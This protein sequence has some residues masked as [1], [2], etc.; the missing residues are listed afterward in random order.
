MEMSIIEF[1]ISSLFQRISTIMMAN[2]KLL[3]IVNRMGFFKVWLHQMAFIFCIQHSKINQVFSIPIKPEFSA[4]RIDLQA[5]SLA[6]PH[7][8]IQG[9]G[10][11]SC[12]TPQQPTIYIIRPYA[13]LY[14]FQ[15]RGIGGY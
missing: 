6:R 4:N 15:P 5:Q 9:D 7:R 3:I 10:T 14:H 1:E 8:T 2:F 11:P 12:T 13:A